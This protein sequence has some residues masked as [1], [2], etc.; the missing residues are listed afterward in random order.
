MLPI[1]FKAFVTLDDLLQDLAADD[2]DARLLPYYDNSEPRSWVEGYT[3]A[4]N[5]L[6]QCEFSLLRP[7]TFWHPVADK[8]FTVNDVCDD[9]LCMVIQVQLGA[10]HVGYGLDRVLD[11][12]KY[13]TIKWPRQAVVGQLTKFGVRVPPSIAGHQDRPALKSEGV[14]HGDPVL[15]GVQAKIETDPERRLRILRELGGRIRWSSGGWVIK[16][17]SALVRHEVAAGWKRKNEK[18]IRKDLKEAADKERDAQR[19][20][21]PPTPW[22]PL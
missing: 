9:F 7:V 4:Q 16:G 22:L 14:V 2:P 13:R 8:A 19:Q 10:G 21:S 17:T 1:N 15:A 6:L 3:L 5:T 18:T 20:E 12:L 11:F